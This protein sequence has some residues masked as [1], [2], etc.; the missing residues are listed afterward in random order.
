MKERAKEQV[1]P[2]RRGG[3]SVVGDAAAGGGPRSDESRETRVLFTCDMLLREERI[4]KN[5]GG[6][7]VSK[8]INQYDLQRS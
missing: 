4:R 8:W 5:E 6:K 7:L 3:G 1:A 2:A